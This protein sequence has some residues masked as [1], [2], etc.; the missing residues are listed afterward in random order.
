M[1]ISFNNLHG[2]IEKN[3]LEE[4]YDD[5]LNNKINFDDRENVI[6]I[7]S[8]AALLINRDEPEY[9]KFA[10]YLIL[11]YSIISK[12]YSPLYEMSYKLFNMPIIEL[13]DRINNTEGEKNLIEE[14]FDIIKENCKE[15]DKYYTGEQKKLKIDFF[16]EDVETGVVAPT[17]FGKTELIKDYIWKNYTDKNICVILPSKAMINQFKVDLVHMFSECNDKPKIITHYDVRIE[18]NRNNIFVFTQER[19]YKFVFDRK[20]DIIFDTL[21]VD[22]AHNIFE[23]DERNKLLAR[24]II[25]L[26]NKN[27]DM[28][29]KYFSPVIEDYNNINFKYLNENY[30]ID[31]SLIVNP[32]IKIE[33][34]MYMNFSDKEK[35]IY[36]QFFNSFIH[37]GITYS[38]EYD[39]LKKEAKSKNIVYLNKPRECIE[40]AFKLYE[41]LIANDD[42]EK[43]SQELK[44]FIHEDYDLAELIKKGIVYHNGIVPENI[45]LYLEN[46]IRKDS[47]NRIKYVF[48]NS[49]LLEGINM[50][51]DNMFIMDICRGRGN[52]TYHD[53]KNLVGRVNRYSLIF[54]KQSKDIN[55]LLPT[56]HFLRANDKSNS[57]FEDFIKNNLKIESR[58]QS[59][60]DV[61]KNPLLS[62]V[63]SEDI[64]EKRIIDNLEQNQNSTVIKTEV[65]KLCLEGNV[66]EFN[67][68]ENESI[69]QDKIEQIRKAD[70]RPGIIKMIFDIF[71][72]D[73]HYIVEDHELIRLENEKAQAFYTMFIDWRRNSTNYNEM[74][75][76]MLTYWKDTNLHFLY[77]GSKWGECKRKVTDRIDNY[78]NLTIKTEKEKVNYAIKKIKIESDFLDYKLMKYIEILYKLSLID[79]DM[80]NEIK[81]GTS[82]EV[83][84]YFQM[85]GLSR[86]LSH[87]LAN[88]YSHFINK[89]EKEEY[90]IDKDIIDNFDENE[91]LKVELEYYL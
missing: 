82:D 22:E 70:E 53:L 84:I 91:I 5:L 50:P 28:I 41:S 45:R 80:Y 23:K 52:L 27:N 4:T 11:K 81:Y 75:N 89:N 43:I 49:T 7:L 77:I 15:D 34:Y 90:I 83:Q 40:K 46:L 57:N 24:V 31:K 54:N 76:K 32:I 47:N 59:R 39:Y 86:E 63:E 68:E 74:I 12:D 61:L 64:N 3:G 87:R 60:K 1:E 78:V 56:I 66:T 35:R 26:K 16:E 65:G 2:M 33:E 8:L 38:D 20:T 10:Y 58:S 14:L 72:K 19:L 69:I 18:E 29:V 85:E 21:L 48:A 71:V 42:L 62:T 67:I 79:Y 36:D 44:G 73:V 37:T 9:R 25:L 17:S 30:K 51:F 88:K 6:K 55:K 13:I